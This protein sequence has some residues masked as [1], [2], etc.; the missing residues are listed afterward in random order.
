MSSIARLVGPTNS[1][2]RSL[3]GSLAHAPASFAAFAELY[4]TFWSHGVVDHPT[5]EAVRLRN[6]RITNCGY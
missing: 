6:A 3:G 5:K 4:G 1:S 2:G